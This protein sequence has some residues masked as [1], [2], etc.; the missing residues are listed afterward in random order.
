MLIRSYPFTG[1]FSTVLRFSERKF[2]E[3]HYYIILFAETK[4]INLKNTILEFLVDSFARP[5][6][7]EIP[8][9]SPINNVTFESGKGRIGYSPCLR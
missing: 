7:C 9:G 4:E 2:P 8:K 6:K 1:Y 3:W 5:L